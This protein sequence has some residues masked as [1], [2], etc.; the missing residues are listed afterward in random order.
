M[1]LLDCVVIFDTDIVAILNEFHHWQN[2]LMGTL[3]RKR[4]D[5]DAN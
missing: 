3:P 2:I 5:V 1:G 4:L